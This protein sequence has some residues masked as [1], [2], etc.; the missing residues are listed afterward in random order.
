MLAER[1]EKL[2]ETSNQL[3]AAEEEIETQRAHRNKEKGELEHILESKEGEIETLKSHL[4]QVR[5]T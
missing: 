2:A 3:E 1:E 5:Y 4:D